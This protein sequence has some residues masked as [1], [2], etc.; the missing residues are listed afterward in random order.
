LLDTEMQAALATQDGAGTLGKQQRAMDVRFEQAMGDQLAEHAA[1]L[2]F[3]EIAADGP[4][5]ELVVLE[6]LH[7]LGADAAQDVDDMR[8]A[9]A[10][11]A[12]VDA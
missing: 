8:R 3:V 4:G 1:P 12:A 9:E 2:A 6:L 10:L 11:A 5:A 7:A